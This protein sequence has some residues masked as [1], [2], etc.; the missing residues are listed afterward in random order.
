M[1]RAVPL[2]ACIAILLAGCASDG[3]SDE[4]AILGE[5]EPAGPVP[6]QQK[7][8]F[9]SATPPMTAIL[10]VMPSEADP[11]ASF[12][13][14]S[15]TGRLLLAFDLTGTGSPLDLRI[16]DADGRTLHEARI[17]ATGKHVAEPLAVAG[18]YDIHASSDSPW[19][20]EAVVTAFPVDYVEGLRLQV[21]TRQQTD[22]E[23]RFYPMQLTTPGREPF[24]ITLYD[25]DPHAG[26][27]NLQ[28][29]VHFP[30]LGLRSEGKTT[31]GEVRALDLP[32]LA[33][34]TY[35]FQCEF[36]GFEGELVVS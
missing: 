31:W 32:P 34:G 6:S 4:D 1:S 12:L 13:A 24:R 20:V 23:H 19:E 36:H 9:A 18:R 28:H 16:T 7:F 5:P 33:S 21:A 25:F 27:A 35:P 14:P 26:T 11:V 17:T 22:V 3:R 8:A 30:T 10:P 29:N 2:L 15:G